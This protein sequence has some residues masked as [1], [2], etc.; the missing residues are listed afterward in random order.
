MVRLKKSCWLLSL[1]SELS[2]LLKSSK[3]TNLQ[4]NAPK[5]KLMVIE[6]KQIAKTGFAQQFSSSNLKRK[7]HRTS[8]HFLITWHANK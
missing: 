3:E 5:T 8:V 6:T 1:Q 2:L 4:F 7:T